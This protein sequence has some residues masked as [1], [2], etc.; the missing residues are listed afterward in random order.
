MKKFTILS[1][2]LVFGFSGQ[3][4]ADSTEIVPGSELYQPMATLRSCNRTEPRGYLWVGGSYNTSCIPISGN[5]W[6]YQFESYFDKPVGSWM[7][8]CSDE[9]VFPDG[10]FLFGYEKFSGCVDG[11]YLVPVIQRYY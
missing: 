9:S 8:V 11:R 3:A 4:S 1:A 5:N 2:V 7:T 10:W 6:A